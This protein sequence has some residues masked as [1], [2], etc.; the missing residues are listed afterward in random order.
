MKPITLQLT[1][2]EIETIRLALEDN[3]T[4]AKSMLNDWGNNLP[5]DVIDAGNQLILAGNILAKLKEASNDNSKK[6]K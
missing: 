1:P 4:C 2:E 5:G 6:K 3:I